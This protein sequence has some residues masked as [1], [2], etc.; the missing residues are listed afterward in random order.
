MV[1]LGGG[2]YLA[3]GKVEQEEGLFAE[4][5]HQ[6]GQRGDVGL[7]GMA[8]DGHDLEHPPMP[9]QPKESTM[10]REWGVIDQS[11]PADLG[12]WACDLTGLL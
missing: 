7:E 1:T 5:Q 10:H 2:G 9:H 6:W 12:L 3:G 11:M 8:G 4:G